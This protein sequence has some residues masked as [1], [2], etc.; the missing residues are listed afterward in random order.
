MNC[1]I[2][3]DIN[4]SKIH[5]NWVSDFNWNFNEKEANISNEF[6]INKNDKWLKIGMNSCLQDIPRQENCIFRSKI[7]GKSDFE[8][9]EYFKDP[10]S[11]NVFEY[12][13]NLCPNDSSDFYNFLLYERK[14]KPIDFNQEPI[15]HWNNSSTF[16]MTPQGSNLPKNLFNQMTIEKVHNLNNLN[17]DQQSYT[18]NKNDELVSFIDSSNAHQD[19]KEPLKS[20]NINNCE[21]PSAKSNKDSSFEATSCQEF[22]KNSNMLDFLFEKPKAQ[23]VYKHDL[24]TRKDVVNKNIVRIIARY[25]KQLLYINFPNHKDW[26]KNKESL[27]KILSDFWL[28]CFPEENPE[29]LK[30]ILGAFVL[31]PKI[32]PLRLDQDVIEKVNNIHNTLSKYSHQNLQKIY[33]SSQIKRVFDYFY[34]YGIE[35]FR[36]EP[37]V[38]K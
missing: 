7:I 27:D 37:M 36:N 22:N 24:S 15:W 23:R 26:L 11:L 10:L 32:K 19:L 34:Q 2:F 20:I 13:S 30:Y 16:D 18:T 8:I 14:I 31:A 29:N 4:E 12:E 17:D 1:G 5:K 3:S 6:L 33:S 25:F 38:W 9:D 35:Y 28:Y 21:S